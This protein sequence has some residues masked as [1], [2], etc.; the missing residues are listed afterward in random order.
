[1]RRI[2]KQPKILKDKVK[3]AWLI[4]KNWKVEMHSYHNNPPHG[5]YWSDTFVNT[6]TSERI[7]IYYQNYVQGFRKGKPN[8]V[9]I[10]SV[11]THNEIGRKEI[12]RLLSTFEITNVNK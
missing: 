8:Y 10:R 12:K 3:L 2:A 9:R 1:M 4:R 11:V 5:M 7:Y 6:E